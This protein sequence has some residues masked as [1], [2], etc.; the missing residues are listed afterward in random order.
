MPT[1]DPEDP[2]HKAVRFGP[3]HEQ[4]YEQDF[5]KQ[6]L[7]RVAARAIDSLPK[8]QRV[9]MIMRLWHDL[10]L[11]QIGKRLG[12]SK[13]RIR[14]IEIQ[15]LRKIRRDELK[16]FAEQDSKKTRP[17]PQP[18]QGEWDRMVRSIGQRAKAGPL[19]TVRDP[20]TGRTRN[21]PAGSLSK[22]STPK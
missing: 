17:N 3:E 8:I 13:D 11:E 21:V 20:E 15:A 4:S 7:K 1:L 18:T 6:E 2:A 10:T 22:K 16:S 19:V 9:V 14:Q 5:D 12:L